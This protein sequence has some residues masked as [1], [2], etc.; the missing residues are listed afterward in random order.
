[1]AGKN[2]AAFGI[3]RTRLDAENGVD[4]LRDAGYRATVISV[5]LPENEGT[6]DFA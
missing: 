6:K 2:T 1:M 5:L 4:A 3:Y